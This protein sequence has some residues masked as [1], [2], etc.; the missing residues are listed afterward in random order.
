MEQ[1]HHQWTPGEATAATESNQDRRID[2]DA[3]HKELIEVF[4]GLT[5][6]QILA[7]G[8]VIKAAKRDM[9]CAKCEGPLGE[10][11]VGSV[12]SEDPYWDDTRT[13]EERVTGHKE[14]PAI[15]WSA[16]KPT[17]NQILRN[18]IGRQT[19]E[20]LRAFLRRASEISSEYEP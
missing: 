17:T 1:A 19:P 6:E 4:A 7:I 2:F 14:P 3:M 12:V 18:F 9:L 11:A 5:P 13:I 10:K 20:Q 15:D 8:E 16:G